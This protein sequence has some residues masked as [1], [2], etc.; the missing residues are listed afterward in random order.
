MAKDGQMWLELLGTPEQFEKVILS[1]INDKFNDAIKKSITGVEEQVKRLVYDNIYNCSE[2]EA[3]R[4]G[5]LRS[6]L[7]LSLRQASGASSDIAQA[8]SESVV[9]QE[10]KDTKK[11]SSGGM[12]VYVQPSNFAN[13]LEVKDSSV[14]YLSKRYKK[15]VKLEWLDWLINRGDEIIV[16]NFG[17]VSSGKGRTGGGRMQKGGS[18]RI[19]PRHA[20]TQEDN[21]ITRALGESSQKEIAS[22]IEKAIKKNWK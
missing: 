17:F 19:S 10:D 11:K 18:W 12:T 9:I 22:I 13:V 1:S 16:A 3:L 8:V 15:N 20:G 21:F 6:E 7:G 14:T 2:L 4:E 5:S